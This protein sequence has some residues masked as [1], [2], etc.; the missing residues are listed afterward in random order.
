[1]VN[2]TYNVVVCNYFARKASAVVDNKEGFLQ[3]R[4]WEYY[5]LS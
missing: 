1:M 5:Y 2:Y 4:F 3:E